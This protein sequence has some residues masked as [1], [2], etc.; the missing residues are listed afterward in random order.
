MNLNIDP[1]RAPHTTSVAIEPETEAAARRVLAQQG[2]ED[3][4]PM[5][6]GELGPV[7]GVCKREAP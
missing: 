4:L 2:A 6:F 1:T 3:L 5:L 7:G